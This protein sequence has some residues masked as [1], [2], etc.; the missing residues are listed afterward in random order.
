MWVVLY[1]GV[2]VFVVDFVVFGLLGWCG[3]VDDVGGYG[4]FVGCMV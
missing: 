4:W 2:V 3:V 1:V